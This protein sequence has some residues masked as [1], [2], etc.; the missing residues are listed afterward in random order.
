M[1]DPVYLRAQ[2]VRMFALAVKT[3]DVDL[4]QMF[5]IRASDY[6]D[7]ALTLEREQRAAQPT[8]KPEA[9]PA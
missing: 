6:F 3:R 7:Q 2:A 9:E 1:A 5:A 8:H 4:A